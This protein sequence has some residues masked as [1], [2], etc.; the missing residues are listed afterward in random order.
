MS[1][2]VSKVAERADRRNGVRNT[3]SVSM[4]IVAPSSAARKPAPVVRWR[5]PE[6]RSEPRRTWWGERVFDVVG[7]I[8]IGVLSLPVSLII[9]VA[10]R[11]S[12]SPVFFHHKRIGRDGKPFDCYK[13]RSMIPDAERVLRDLLASDPAA[14]REWERTYK[15]QDDPRITRLGH[16]LRKSSLDELPQLWNVLRGE[17]SLVGPRPIV[18]EELIRYGRYASLYTAVRPGMTGL[19]QVTG[20]SDCTYSRRVSLD[21]LYVL[22]KSIRVDLMIMLRTI[23]VVINRVGAV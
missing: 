15:L 4:D 19:W 12:G 6:T 11:V 5:R 13:F 9:A 1:N 21:K 23:K 20:R 18:Q 17:M 7:A 10:I 14:M 3:L 16:F 2:V 8:T 22:K